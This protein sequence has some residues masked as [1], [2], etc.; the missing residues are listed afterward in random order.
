[1]GD[2]LG[3]AVGRE[4]GEIPKSNKEVLGL[5]MES[6]IHCGKF[7]RYINISKHIKIKHV[8]IRGLL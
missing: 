3:E 4:G 7:S 6:L 2:C 8:N 5:R 1:M